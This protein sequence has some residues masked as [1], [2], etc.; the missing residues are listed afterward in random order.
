MLKSL[1][2]AALTQKSLFFKVKL[3]NAFVGARNVSFLKDES[4]F[5]KDN[6]SSMPQEADAV[7][8]GAGSVGCST[9]YHLSKLLGG[10]IILLEKHKITS[11]T[12]WHTAG[13]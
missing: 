11:G 1:F 7:V 6:L 5:R 3:R 9:A 2:A 13:M 12:T 8:I 4:T 10:N